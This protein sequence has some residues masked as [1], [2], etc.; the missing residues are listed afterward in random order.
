MEFDLDCTLHTNTKIKCRQNGQICSI[1]ENKSDIRDPM[2]A[3]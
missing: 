3:E 1:G 2:A